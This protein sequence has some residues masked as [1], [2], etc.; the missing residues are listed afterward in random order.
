MLTGPRTR[1]AYALQ[2]H[3]LQKGYGCLQ[4]DIPYKEVS[5]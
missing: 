2:G 5:A 1:I 4:Y 3:T